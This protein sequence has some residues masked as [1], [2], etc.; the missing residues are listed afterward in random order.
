VTTPSSDAVPAPERPD[1]TKL[2][3]WQRWELGSLDTPSAASA[4]Q[5][6][7]ARAEAYAMA[8][9]E[10]HAAGYVAGIAQAASERARLTELIERLSV[11]AADHEQR[12]CD[13]VL[14]LALVLARQLVG[15]ALSVRREFVL[16]VVSAALKQLPQSTQ[17]VELFVNP[18]DLA[19]VEAHVS[20]IETGARCRIS[21]N[22]T[23]APGG[24]K[25]E[26]EQCEI[27]MTSPTRWRRLLALLGRS[28]DWIEPV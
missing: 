11:C 10:G 19:L 5:V 18:A 21:G 23:I 26:T 4:S 1:S 2:S 27:D 20:E 25:V 7:N 13:E 8:Q 24:C 17:R 16:P 15:E 14:D 9:R 12:L 28:D 22:A 3:A 6:A